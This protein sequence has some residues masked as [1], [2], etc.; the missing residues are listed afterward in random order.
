[1][2]GGGGLSASSSATATSGDV[3]ADT[4]IGGGAEGNRGNNQT[5]NF[6]SGQARAVNATSGN[7]KLPLPLLIVGGLL[8]LVVIGII[9][10]RR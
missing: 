4:R 6:T 5:F 9:V 1:M 10:F 2:G 8:S 7:A 3:K